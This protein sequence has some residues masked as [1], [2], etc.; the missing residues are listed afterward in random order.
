MDVRKMQVAVEKQADTE[1]LEGPVATPYLRQ[2]QSRR[3]TM[4]PAKTRL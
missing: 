4:S 2:R 1:L 3:F